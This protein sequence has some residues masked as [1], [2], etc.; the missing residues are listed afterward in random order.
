M[1]YSERGRAQWLLLWVLLAARAPRAHA[2]DLF[3]NLTFGGNLAVTSNYIYRG[4]SESNGDPAGQVDL[5]AGTADG[6]FIGVWGSTRDRNF[7][8]Y[9]H[10]DLEL[11]LGHRFA[12]SND[13]GATL[14]ARSRYYLGGSQEVS[15]D[16][17][18][19]TAS[20]SY[21]DAWSLSVTAIPNAVKYWFNRRLGRTPAWVADTAGQ[22]LIVDGF[23]LTGG[24]GYYHSSGS[25]PG[26][27]AAN[28]YAYGNAG[29]AYEYRHWRIDVGYFLAQYKAREL[30][31][32]PM[33]SDR[34]AAT[35]TWRF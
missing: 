29:V 22:W 8:P 2:Q 17:Q 15:D 14:S 30:F 9:A 1:H 25:G 31:P 18:E 3:S 4:V 11:Y 28:G 20:V 34:V 27:R 33:A 35:L 32:Y 26:I 21:L 13:W 5:H 24:A 6:S 10:Y 16:Y 19:I 7:E 23:F 12:L